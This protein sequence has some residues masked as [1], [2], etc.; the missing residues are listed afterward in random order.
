MLEEFIKLLEKAEVLD[1]EPKFYGLNSEENINKVEKALQLKFD[2][3]LK[4]YLLKFGG[5]GMP[6]LLHTN[7]ILPENPLSN[8]IYTLYGATVY[9]RQEF[10]L[11]DNFLVINS[12]FPSDILVLDTS[13]GTIYSYEI[14]SKNRS[15]TLYPNFENYLLTEWDALIQEY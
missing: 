13:S 8:D 11:P 9:A 6:D 10:H 15:S 4:A 1:E 7:G 5:G 2:D 14:L 3:C 12:N